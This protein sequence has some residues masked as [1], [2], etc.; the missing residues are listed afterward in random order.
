[1]TELNRCTIELCNPPNYN[2]LSFN[3]MDFAKVGLFFTVVGS[4]IQQSLLNFSK[5]QLILDRYHIY[6]S[7]RPLSVLFKNSN[8]EMYANDIKF[9]WKGKQLAVGDIVT[10]LSDTVTSPH[11]MYSLYPTYTEFCLAVTFLNVYEFYC[12]KKL[13]NFK[14]GNFVRVKHLFSNDFVEIT[15]NIYLFQSYFSNPYSNKILINNL[16][17][18]IKSQFTKVDVS[19]NSI[20]SNVCY[21]DINNLNI[22]NDNDSDEVKEYLLPLQ[23]RLK[24]VINFAIEVS[25]KLLNFNSVAV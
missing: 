9:N 18:D 1:M 6:L 21:T 11:K 12:I 7:L 23:E 13:K 15:D 19:I 2:Y 16:T 3:N 22:P 14:F 8:F 24:S 20:P 5:H 17:R 10:Y 25:S 4:E